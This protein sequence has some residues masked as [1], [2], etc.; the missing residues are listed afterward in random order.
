MK[1]SFL[2]IGLP[3]SGE[4]N[5]DLHS[6]V[7]NVLDACISITRASGRGLG[8]GVREF[9]RPCEMTSEPLVLYFR[10]LV[11]SLLIQAAVE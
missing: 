7:H 3:G 8:P 11:Y 5:Y 9:F 4:V 2:L 10:C 1:D 6:P